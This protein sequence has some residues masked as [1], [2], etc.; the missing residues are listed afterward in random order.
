MQRVE[1]KEKEVAVAHFQFIFPFSFKHGSEDD[2]FPFLKEQGFKHFELGDLESEHAYYGQFEVSHLDIESFYLPFTNQILFPK[3]E[4][5]KGIQRYSK[6]LDLNGKLTTQLIQ[7]PFRIHS[8]DITLCPYE[9]GFLTIRTSVD[10]KEEVSLSSALEFASRFRVLQPKKKRD[11]ST[12][13]ECEG[14]VYTRVQDFIFDSLFQ[15]LTVFFEK[16]NLKATYFETFPFFEDERFYVQ[17]L[18]SLKE[19]MTIDLEDNYR[20]IGLCGL[21]F[22]GTPYISANNRPYMETYLNEHSYN[23]WAPNTY[24]LME[25]EAF[26]CL[27]NEPMDKVSQIAGEVYGQF[28]YGLLLNLFHKIVLLKIAHSYAGLNIEQDRKEM[29][30]LIYSINSFTANYFFSEIASQSQG[31]D[32]FFQLRKTFNIELL[33]N[34]A[35]QTLYSLFKYQENANA[36]KDSLLLLILTLYSVIG[37]MFGMS[38]VIGDFV[39]K[40]KWN[41]I[42]S[43]NPIEYFALFVAVTGVAVSLFLGISNVCQWMIDRR[44]REKWVKQTVLSSA[45]EKI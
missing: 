8:I 18:I 30:K 41:Q 17:A 13:I 20:S 34:D 37:Q 22:D 2:I 35:R 43:F 14:I 45:K 5:E 32:L 29:E 4:Q 27:T 12:R 21:D 3:K 23:R 9:L 40:I 16:K 6:S 10:T 24:F 25:E 44:N 26:I 19:D 15:D 39:G 1:V 42:L 11:Q 31:R 36:K 38:L 28:Y 33:Y 7:T